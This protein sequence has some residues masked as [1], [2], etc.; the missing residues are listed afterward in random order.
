MILITGATGLLG[1]RLTAYL[2][3]AGFSVITHGKSSKA[4]F[5]V[6]LCDSEKSWNLLSSIQ[7]NIILN[8]VSLTNV[9]ECENNVNVAYMANTHVVENL[10]HW[11]EKN[12]ATCHLIQI[13]TDH[14][15][16]GSELHSEDAVT[17]TNTYAFSKY[18]GELA[19]MRVPSSILRTNFIGRSKISHRESL[20]DWVYTS[21]I[22][23]KKIQVLDDVYFSPLSMNTLVE[24]IQLVIERKPV[25]IFNLGSHNGMSKA[26]FSFH[27][28]QC[29][30][31][32]THT[33]S[34]IDAQQATFIKT[35]RPKD[36]RMDCSKFENTLGVKL[37]QF[38]E[39][40]IRV[41]KEYNEAC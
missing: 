11:I 41:A 13:S 26:N 19:A 6:D 1:S 10:V 14:V 21:L 18:A 9:D 5:M 33:V 39:E 25:G 27:F 8:L 36:M 4:D 31:L 7:P 37:P 35:Y 15:Y 38:S 23:T 12:R 17:L 28:A 30:K 40:I 24:M 2:K 22:N 16:D 29:L 3:L 20:S 34:R 32:P